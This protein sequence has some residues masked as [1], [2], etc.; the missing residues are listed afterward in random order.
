MEENELDYPY[1]RWGG[2]IYRRC[3]KLLGDAAAAEDATQDVFVRL[4]P[5][6]VAPA[7]NGLESQE[8]T[9]R[10]SRCRLSGAHSPAR[11]ST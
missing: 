6:S 7:P 9:P 3:L 2:E 4:M 8:P 1:R 11:R 5:A 10:C